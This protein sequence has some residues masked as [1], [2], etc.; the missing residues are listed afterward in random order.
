MWADCWLLSALV[1]L[2]FKRPD[3]LVDLFEDRGDGSYQVTFPG[4]APVMARPD[5]G[6][7]T[8]SEPWP[9]APVVESASQQIMDTKTSRVTTFG[10]GIE[11]LSGNGRT[12]YTNLMGLGFAPVW[13]LP[14]KGWFEKCLA[15]ATAKRRL[16]VLGGS[17]GKLVRPKQA[18]ISPEH[19]Y[20]I[21]DYD[22]NSNRVRLRDPRG[23]DNSVPNNA[24]PLERKE[25]GYGPG[26]FWLA[27][28]EVEAS[29]CG[30]SIE[31]G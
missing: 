1:G 5:Q 19:C 10:I 15:D 20:A 18:W 6:T 14:R 7:G 23:I 3:E 24:I 16:I 25:T 9:W 27:P 11:L 13:A 2:A 30:L 28:D 8:V 21:L 17:D 4:R 22:T 12:G 29:F 31:N 26:E